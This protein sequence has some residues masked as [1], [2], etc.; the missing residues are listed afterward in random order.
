MVTEDDKEA[1]KLL[2]GHITDNLEQARQKVQEIIEQR[3]KSNT[4]IFYEDYRRVR[5]F[6]NEVFDEDA[7]RGEIRL[8]FLPAGCLG[9]IRKNGENGLVLAALKELVSEDRNEAR[10]VAFVRDF[11]YGGREGLFFTPWDI[12]ELEK[13]GKVPIDEKINLHRVEF[14]REYKKHGDYVTSIFSA[15]RTHPL[16]DSNSLV[17]YIPKQSVLR[18]R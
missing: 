7:Y 4:V 12:N 16:S 6:F 15:W 9:R 1:L 8:A 2:Y 13:Q 17:L 14:S 10:L 5:S 11:P 18:I 3:K